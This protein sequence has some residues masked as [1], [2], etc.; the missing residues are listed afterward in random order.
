MRFFFR[1]VVSLDPQ[2]LVIPRTLLA[3]PSIYSPD[4]TTPILH[5]IWNNVFQIDYPT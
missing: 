5:V 4:L 3:S 2:S 1:F